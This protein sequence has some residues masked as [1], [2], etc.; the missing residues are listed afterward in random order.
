MKKDIVEST[1]R[2]LEDSKLLEIRKIIEFLMTDLFENGTRTYLDGEEIYF[3]KVKFNTDGDTIDKDFLT[4]E[5]KELDFATINDE[6]LWSYI[7][8]EFLLQCKL[9]SIRGFGSTQVQTY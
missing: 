1:A 8:G 3:K 9:E 5:G 4:S 6:E 7:Y 2:N